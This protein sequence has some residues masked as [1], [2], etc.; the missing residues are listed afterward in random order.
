VE[1]D[2]KGL[3]ALIGRH[4]A[5]IL[6]WFGVSGLGYTY[7]G[8]F[9]WL[10]FAARVWKQPLR[11]HPSCPSVSVIIAARN[12]AS[13][14]R[15][16]IANLLDL[17][18]RSEQMQIIIASDG[19]TD[20]T[21]EILAEHSDRI[22]PIVLEQHQGKAA[23]LNE[24]VKHAEGEILCFFDVR[25]RI[26]HDAILELVQPFS[27]PTVGVVSGLLQIDHD[28]ESGINAAL[29]QYWQV[30][31]RIRILESA[32][33]SSVGATG[34]IY[35][36]RRNLYT[37]LPH[38]TILD[39]VFIPMHAVL[40]G[41]RVI[42]EPRAIARDAFSEKRGREFSRKVRTLTGNYQL[43]KIAPWLITPRNPL[44]FRFVS[45]KVLRLLSPFLLILILFASAEADGV[46]Y[47]FVFRLHILLYFCF[48]LTAAIPATRRFRV[49]GLIHTFSSLNV[50][51]LVAFFRFVFGRSSTW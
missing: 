11:T 20:A 14:L 22:L 36:I 38:G 28:M 45:H 12:E 2:R 40:K 34:A 29:E 49:L 42:F 18:Y 31:T 30:E 48:A 19:S 17:K 16:R 24:A 3:E 50:A 23:A 7:V 1:S 32:S 5:E 46:F 37:Q 8:Y 44:L 4:Y 6:F 51:A 27:D 10:N 21:A 41:K 9:A 26:N 43:L 15:Q 25:Q 47:Q 13:G 33:G 35:A 39:D